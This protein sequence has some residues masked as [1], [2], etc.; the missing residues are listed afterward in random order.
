MDEPWHPG[1]HIRFSIPKYQSDRLPTFPHELTE[2]I[3]DF[4]WDEPLDIVRCLLVCHAWYHAARHH[5]NDVGSIRSN[6]ALR[7]LAHILVGKRMPRY[8]KIIF[9]LSL[10]EHASSP[11]VHTFP[12]LVPGS[13]CPNVDRL[14]ITNIDWAAQVTPH[15]EFFAYLSFYTS[16]RELTLARCRF[17][18]IEQLNKLVDSLPSL[19]TLRLHRIRLAPG[20]DIQMGHIGSTSLDSSSARRSTPMCAHRAL[21]SLAAPGSP[22]VRLALDVRYFSSLQV[23]E[24]ILVALPALTHLSLERDPT[25]FTSSQ[26]PEPSP[27]ACNVGGRKQTRMP[28]LR[29]IALRYIHSAS[30]AHLLVWISTIWPCNNVEDLT[31]IIEDDPS[32]ALQAIFTHVLCLS[33]ATLKAIYWQSLTTGRPIQDFV[34]QYEHIATLETL[35]LQYYTLHE[36]DARLTL[37]QINEKLFGLLSQCAGTPHL[38]HLLIR[39]PLSADSGSLLTYVQ[40]VESSHHVQ[41]PG[42]VAEFHDLLT[43]GVFT[44]LPAGSV[45]LIVVLDESSGAGDTPTLI[46]SILNI[47]FT[48]W[49]DS[50]VMSLVVDHFPFR[51]Q[52]ALPF[53]H[54]GLHTSQ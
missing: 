17:R 25:W 44:Q 2:R 51:E 15:R 3:V 21:L 26:L 8:G 46:T 37:S 29:E 32:S 12:M 38:Q 43:K 18:S 31:V 14:D 54:L 35:D 27:G 28:A 40:H 11:Y 16:I 45:A 4:L 47:L 7:S 52:D 5:V 22:L 33:A 36:V 48:P 50:G 10:S 39:Y 42:L 19:D 23:L 41:D 1:D 34:P 6:T 49:L 53:V 20:S 24:R 13:L 9:T 30:A